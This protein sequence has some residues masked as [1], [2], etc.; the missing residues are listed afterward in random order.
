MQVARMTAAVANGGKL[1]TPHVAAEIIGSDGK[2]VRT[3]QPEWKQVPVEPRYLAD[4]RQGMHQSVLDGAGA[5]GG[6]PGIDIAGK[7]GTAEFIDRE[8][9]KVFEHAWFTGFAPFDNPE[10]VV[11][12]YFD[13]GVGGSKAAPVASRIFQ[14]Y[15][16]NV[17]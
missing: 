17:R 15:W 10:I 4:I 5:L 1:L 11:T 13:R 3:I 8:S 2:V 14:Y 9:G 12:V 7:T 16:E 6:A